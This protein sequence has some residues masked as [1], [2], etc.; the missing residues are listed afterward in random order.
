MG[1]QDKGNANEQG[2]GIKAVKKYTLVLLGLCLGLCSCMSVPVSTMIRM[3]GFS[4]R[5]IQTLDPNEV[6][7]KVQ[8]PA[9]HTL[10]PETTFIEVRLAKL[11]QDQQLYRFPLEVVETQSETQGWWHKQEITNFTLRLTQEGIVNFVKLQELIRSQIKIG[12]TSISVYSSFDQKEKI[13]VPYIDISIF[14][15]LE[16]NEDYFTL[17]DDARINFDTSKIRD[18]N[19]VK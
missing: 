18:P 10:K 3:S 8:L 19:E 9:T 1:S 12:P 14:L 13:I 5:D 6:R 4:A 16:K 7:V 15:K 11:E 2:K 17:I